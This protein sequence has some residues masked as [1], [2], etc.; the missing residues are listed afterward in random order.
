MF[1]SWG[2][3]SIATDKI[4]QKECDDGVIVVLRDRKHVFRA[5]AKCTGSTIKSKSNV[6]QA[7]ALPPLLT[8]GIP[9]FSFMK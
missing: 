2:R 8:S 7:S 3:S 1:A 6:A 4:H 5:E 9:L